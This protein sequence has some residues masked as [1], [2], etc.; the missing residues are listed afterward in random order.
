MQP[1]EEDIQKLVQKAKNGEAAG[2]EQLFEIFKNK[3]Y[4]FFIYRVKSRETAED[5][6]QTV[7]LEMIRSFVRYKNKRRAKFSTWLFQ[8]ARFRLIDHYRQ[9]KET[10]PIDSIMENIEHHLSVE[11]EAV[12]LDNRSKKM[13]RAIGQLPEKHQ[14]ILQLSYSQEMSNDEIAGVMR[15]TSLN[16]RVIKF[17]ALKKLKSILK[18]Y[19]IS[20]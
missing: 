13:W 6:T 15:T 11:P 10:V 18:K 3:I 14:T 19:E 4:R 8:I 20:R 1:S 12:H 9:N 16:V 17:R 5:L 2:I 7:F